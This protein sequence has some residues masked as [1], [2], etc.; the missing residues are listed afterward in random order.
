[1]TSRR[2]ERR[3]AAAAEKWRKN[4]ARKSNR[5]APAD[6]KKKKNTAIARIGRFGLNFASEEISGR[7]R[8]RAERAHAFISLKRRANAES[9]P[10]IIK[11]AREICENR[12]SSLFRADELNEGGAFSN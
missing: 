11:S 6:E 8:S 2:N 9:F 4:A 7:N 12:A 3:A 1:M 5:G 10:G